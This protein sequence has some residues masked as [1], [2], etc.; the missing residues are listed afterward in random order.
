[1]DGKR[2]AGSEPVRSASAPAPATAAPA[3]PRDILV[4]D[5]DLLVA[6]STVTMLEQVGYRARAAADGADALDILD[7]GPEVGLMVTD[8][9]LPGMNGHD[10]ARE[11]RRRRPDLK[12]VFVTGYDRRTVAKRIKPDDRTELL[13]KPY[14]PGDLIAAIRRLFAPASGTPDPD[15]ETI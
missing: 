15:T 13:G 8:I 1:M 4:V 7:R 5:D 14:H 3:S 6:E 9:G 11:A 12:I 10:L 2:P